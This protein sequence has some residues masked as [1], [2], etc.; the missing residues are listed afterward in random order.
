MS[1][2]RLTDLEIRLAWQEDLLRTLEDT[3]HAQQTHVGE[4]E[5]FCRQLAERLR[6]LQDGHDANPD[7]GP[8][9]HY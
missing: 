2:A 8:P 1:D 3:L 7:D 4:L 6:A 5:T 9:P